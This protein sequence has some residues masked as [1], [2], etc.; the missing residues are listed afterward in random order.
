MGAR[1]TLLI[2]P[3]SGLKLDPRDEVPT[4]ALTQY[5]RAWGVDVGFQFGKPLFDDPTQTDIGAQSLIEQSR[6]TAS[7]PTAPAVL[8]LA[9]MALD[10]GTTNGI[11]LDMKTR[12]A[13]AVFINSHAYKGGSHDEKFQIYAHEIGHVLNLT[14]LEADEDYPTAMSQWDDRSEVRDAGELWRLAIE[15]A[16]MSHR[17]QMKSFFRDGKGHLLGLP[18]SANCC[19][20]LARS[21]RAQVEPWG[22]AFEDWSD[23]G[24]RDVRSPVQ[25]HLRIQNRTLSIAHPLA[26]DI[27]LR[28]APGATAAEVPA[29][30][31]LRSRSLEIHLTLP[32]GDRQILAPGTRS[33]GGLQRRLRSGKVARANY[34][35]LSDRNGLVLPVAGHYQIQAWLPQLGV[36]SRPV[37]F[38]VDDSQHDEAFVDFLRRGM[39]ADHMQSW[40]RARAQLTDDRVAIEAKAHVVWKAASQRLPLP[41]A[42]RFD[43]TQA[44]PAIREDL[45]MLKIARLTASRKVNPKAIHVAI[46]AA[47][48]LFQETDDGHPSL[49]YLAHLRRTLYFKHGKGRNN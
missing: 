6:P 38:E 2:R 39:P 14:H 21:I 45:A 19:V 20:A 43:L 18:M 9:D 40:M 47:E 46:D 35:V 16:S 24:I 22:D 13:C 34:C 33:C 15:S 27:E 11:L 26:F 48:E 10:G 44:P 12:G 17:Q 32:N 28:L 1:A 7:Q 49:E 36:V 30:L 29:S 37:A 3:L 25:C 23:E 41:E 31:D 4:E 42:K 8:V 5:F